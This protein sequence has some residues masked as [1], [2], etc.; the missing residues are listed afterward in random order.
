MNEGMEMGMNRG[1]TVEE[2]K[3][4]EEGKDGGGLTFS[5]L[6]SPLSD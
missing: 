3:Q 2:R 5:Y 1:K 6:C 4:G